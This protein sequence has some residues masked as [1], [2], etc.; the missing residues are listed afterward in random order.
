MT[1]KIA[2]LDDDGDKTQLEVL[3]AR[4]RHGNFIR[5]RE[6]EDEVV[7]TTYE[8]AGLISALQQA[9]EVLND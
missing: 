3:I 5:L 7:I 1:D 9:Q 4:T 6:F 8:L 2:V